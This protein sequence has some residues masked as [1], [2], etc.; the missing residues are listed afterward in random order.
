MVRKLCPQRFGAVLLFSML[1]PASF[2]CE[3]VEIR[4]FCDALPDFSGQGR[5]IFVGAV[6]EVYPKSIK[7]Y[8]E[9]FAEYLGP[10]IMKLARDPADRDEPI[11]WEQQKSFLLH[12]WR[13]TF[14]EKE[15]A[16]VKSADS[17]EALS[18]SLGDMAYPQRRA[19]LKVKEWFAG[20]EQKDFELFTG[21]GH[22]DCGAGFEAGGTYLVSAY[23]SEE[24]GRWS[25]SACSRTYP[26]SDAED[27]LKALRAWKEGKRWGGPLG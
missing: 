15:V 5:A 20:D 19:R 21:M 10:E 8:M 26:I 1:A 4:P 27:D 6:T 25:T 24:T 7:H 22:G 14:T 23:Q 16:L 17:D 18:E 9:L 12:L 2:A 11:P 13:D 3:C